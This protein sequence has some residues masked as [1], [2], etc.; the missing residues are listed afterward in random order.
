MY[1]KRF[2]LGLTGGTG[3]GKS[4]AAS[5]LAKNGGIVIDADAIS[6]A[7]MQ[8]GTAALLEVTASFPD[9]LLD[10]GSLNRKKLAAIVFSDKEQLARLNAITHT[11]IT[12]EIKKTINET[13]AP[14]IV[15]DAP[16]LFEAGLHRL[17]QKTLCVLSDRDLRKA[18]IMQRDAL[19]EK[20][21]LARINAQKDDDYYKSRCDYVLHNTGELA[22]LEESLSAVLKEIFC[23]G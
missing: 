22:S 12:N 8:P 2:V 7:L 6:R 5:F 17:C 19:T 14:L 21:A 15:L 20:E 3:C 16:L 1:V 10:D 9:I 4:T 18:R 13:Q 11:Y 23:E